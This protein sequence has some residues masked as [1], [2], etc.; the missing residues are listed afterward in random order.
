MGHKY[1]PDCG[2]GAVRSPHGRDRDDAA[3]AADHGGDHHRRPA[4][5]G[6][7]PCAATHAHCSQPGG[8]AYGGDNPWFTTLR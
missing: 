3:E 4:G 1:N 2:C 7:E 6:A 8:R 5:A